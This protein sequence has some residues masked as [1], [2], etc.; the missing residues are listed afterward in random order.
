MV[1][2]LNDDE[3]DENDTFEDPEIEDGEFIHGAEVSP[4]IELMRCGI[5][6]LQQATRD[7][8][9]ANH[10]GTFLGKLK[11]LLE[12]EQT[13]RIAASSSGYGQ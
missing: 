9:A 11:H 6:T 5:H 12:G 10:D 1:D 3:D 4:F 8:L 2:K 13:Q 7:G